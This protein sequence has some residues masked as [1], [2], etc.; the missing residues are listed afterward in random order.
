MAVLVACASKHGSTT[1]L[2]QRIAAALIENGVD[3][4]VMR[5]DAV[6]IGSS[7]YFGHWM[8]E[9]VALVERNRARLAGRPIWFFSVGPLGDQARTDPAEI[10]GLAASVGAVER[11]SGYHVTSPGR[12]LRTESRHLGFYDGVDPLGHDV[13]LLLGGGIRSS[14]CGRRVTI[15]SV[16]RTA[17]KG[18]ALSSGGIGSQYCFPRS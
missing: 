4:K 18:D 11:E 6:V 2:A 16:R 9:A 5:V 12:F 17:G 13:V 8:R 3:A 7:V 10:E 15:T 1:E 14:R